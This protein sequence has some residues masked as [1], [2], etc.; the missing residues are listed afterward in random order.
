VVESY[1]ELD[2]FEVFDL[3]RICEFVE[4]GLVIFEA[5]TCVN[6]T[7]G[8]FLCIFLKFDQQTNLSHNMVSVADFGLRNVNSVR[9]CGIALVC[10]LVPNVEVKAMKWVVR[11]PLRA[12]F[13]VKHALVESSHIYVFVELISLFEG[14]P[15]ETHAHSDGVSDRN[16]IGI[17]SENREVHVGCTV[18]LEK[19]GIVAVV[20]EGLIIILNP[21]VETII[22]RFGTANH[23]HSLKQKVVLIHIRNQLHP[24]LYLVKGVTQ[25]IS[26]GIGLL[27]TLGDDRSHFV[28]DNRVNFV[29]R[30]AEHCPID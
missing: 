3:A 22:L 2:A 21:S 24:K 11:L 19:V 7:I 9:A 28:G 10:V 4:N 30:R 27:V 29:L 17:K 8:V 23:G 16:M 15:G 25:S 18:P 6:P 26:T 5:A 13:F 14:G 20:T 1:L 12:A